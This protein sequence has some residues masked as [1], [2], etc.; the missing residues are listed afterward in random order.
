MNTIVQNITPQSSSQMSV[1]FDRIGLRYGR[2]DEIL[3]DISFALA[4]GSLNFVTGPSGA[5]KTSLLKLMYLHMRPSRG[6]ITLFGQ[7]V[8]LLGKH[9][10]P[11]LKRRMGVVL[12]DFQLI[13][14]LNVF[15][16]TA[17]PLRIAGKKRGEYTQ[18]V[19]SLLQ[20]VGLGERLHALTRHFIWRRKT[21]RRYCA[22]HYCKT[23]YFNCRRTNRQCRSN[24]C[25]TAYP[26]ICGI[27]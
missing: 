26:F 27:K 13:N 22:R 24:Y 8:A 9:Q 1:Q 17:L 18:D 20:W 2:G 10:I 3:S 16:N 23:G 12:Q 21:A 15:E 4:S 19:V 7:D 6:L 14:H 25:K 5:G 11:P